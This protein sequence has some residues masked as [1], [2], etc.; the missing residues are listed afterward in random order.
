MAGPHSARK[1]VDHES[2]G[3]LQIHSTQRNLIHALHVVGAD[4]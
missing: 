2:K 4:R 3:L 1:I